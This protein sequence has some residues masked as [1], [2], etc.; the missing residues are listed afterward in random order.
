M[1]RTSIK[2]LLKSYANLSIIFFGILFLNEKI[3]LFEVP[4][5]QDLMNLYVIF[6]LILSMIYYRMELKD[7]EKVIEGLKYKLE[8][9]NL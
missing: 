9:K 8:K 1:K 2:R 6:Y 4:N 7:K 5:S 3:N